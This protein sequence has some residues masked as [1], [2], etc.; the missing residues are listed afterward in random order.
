MSILPTDQSNKWKLACDMLIKSV[1]LLNLSTSDLLDMN[2]GY[3]IDNI[4]IKYDLYRQNCKI[5]H[6]ISET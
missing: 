5:F 3:D 1:H 6:F 2:L 4:K